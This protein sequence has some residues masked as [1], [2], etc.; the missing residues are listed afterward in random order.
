MLYYIRT[1][2]I[3]SSAWADTPRQAAVDTLRRSSEGCGE[4][5]IVSH[6]EIVD[7]E[8]EENIFFL[9]ESIME[10]CMGMRIIG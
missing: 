10:D 9:T 3:H 8:S 7:Y 2:D 5:T 1:G 6:E 4:L